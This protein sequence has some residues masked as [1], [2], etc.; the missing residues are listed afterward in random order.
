MSPRPCGSLSSCGSLGWWYRNI[1]GHKLRHSTLGYLAVVHVGLIKEIGRSIMQER[2]CHQAL[3][4]QV[5]ADDLDML[6]LIC[7]GWRKAEFITVRPPK[8]KPGYQ[9]P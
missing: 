1:G 2:V 4:R 8:A 7:S 5:S 6:C 9:T 3:L